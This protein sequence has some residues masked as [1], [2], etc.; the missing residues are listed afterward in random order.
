MNPE[1]K[2]VSI[3]VII[4][5]LVI[6]GGL[7]L[8]GN[9]APAAQVN[10]IKEALVSSSTPVQG[11]G[12]AKVSV[13]EFADFACPACAQLHPQL[14][15]VLATYPADVSLSLRLIPIHNEESIKSAIAAYAAKEQGKFFEMGDLLF[16]N[17]SAWAGKSAAESRDLF[18]QYATTLGL[19]VA[20]FTSQIDSADFRTQVIAIVDQ[21]NADSKKMG[22]QSTP[23][24]V[25]NATTTI[26]G[27]QSA[28]ALGKVFEGFG[29]S[30][31]TPIK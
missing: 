6:V 14:K 23:T 18:I 17:Q 11:P 9:N 20:Q 19:N 29:A 1:V 30:T 2:V 27:V 8:T 13:V 21:D 3:I 4:T 25:V 15:A 10:I 31:S 7:S 5:A 12:Q 24:L 22:I 16:T 26:I 28:A